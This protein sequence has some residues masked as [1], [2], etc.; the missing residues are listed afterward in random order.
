MPHPIVA[1]L[2]AAL[3]QVREKDLPLGA[4]LRLISD[5]VATE[6]PDFAVAVDRFVARLEAAH[7]GANAPQVGDTMPDFCLPDQDGNLVMLGSLLTRG[8]VAVAF[9]RGR[10]CPYCRLNMTGLASIEDAAKPAQIVAVSSQTAQH[11]RALRAEAGA[12]LP[13]LSD[14]GGGYALSLNL[15]IWVDADMAA[16]IAGAGWDIPT[17]QGGGGWVLPV[18]AVFVVGRDGVIAARHVDPDY[19]KRMELEDLLGA[20]ARL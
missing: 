10:W 13:F 11:S 12:S 8:P 15:A 1:Q 20:L 18:P 14:V 19:R 9:H 6:A 4:R 2:E 16:L 3:A 7:A 17:Y 5:F